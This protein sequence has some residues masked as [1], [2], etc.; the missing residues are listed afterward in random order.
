MDITIKDTDYVILIRWSDIDYHNELHW[1]MDMLKDIP[2]IRELSAEE[3]SAAF[4]KI[5]PTYTTLTKTWR[6]K[7][8]GWAPNM[9]LQITKENVFLGQ[10][11]KDYLVDYDRELDYY[12]IIKD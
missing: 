9:Y 3:I 1:F 12:R 6:E 7:G 11:A 10:A 5:A 8:E 2:H 4:N